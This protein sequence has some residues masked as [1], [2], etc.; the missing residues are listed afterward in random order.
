M[1]LKFNFG[2]ILVECAYLLIINSE[3][4]LTD[5]QYETL[6]IMDKLHHEDPDN[7]LYTSK[8]FREYPEAQIPFKKVG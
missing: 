4:L 1:K 7:D 8:Y 3:G 2:T 6:D 5:P